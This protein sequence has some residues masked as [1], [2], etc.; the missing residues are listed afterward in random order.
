MYER[1]NMLMKKV[2]LTAISII[3][4]IILIVGLAGCG[5]IKGESEISGVMPTKPIN[6]LSE[7]GLKQLTIISTLKRYGL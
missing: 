3:S 4:F 6:S 1:G 7:N 2:N 5:S